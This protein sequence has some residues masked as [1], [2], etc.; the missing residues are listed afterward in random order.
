MILTH[1]Q[2]VIIALVFCALL[3]WVIYDLFKK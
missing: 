3:A 1:F 2:T